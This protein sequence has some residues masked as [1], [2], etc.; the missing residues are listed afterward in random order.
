[1][2]TICGVEC[3]TCHSTLSLSGLWVMM[4]TWGFRAPGLLGAWSSMD[5]LSASLLQ[6][7]LMNDDPPEET[8]SNELSV[9]KSVK[10]WYLVCVSET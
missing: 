2:N 6:P 3:E 8:N 1:M 7:G 4:M 10:I 5:F 9:T